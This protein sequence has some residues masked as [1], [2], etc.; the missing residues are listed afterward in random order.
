[1]DEWIGTYVNGIDDRSNDSSYRCCLWSLI[2]N[3]FVR[4]LDLQR[5]D[6]GRP[7]VIA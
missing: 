5:P 4:S 1:M 3:K 7:S 2:P 6:V